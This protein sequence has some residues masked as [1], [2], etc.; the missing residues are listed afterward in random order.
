MVCKV[1]IPDRRP[2]NSGDG[3]DGL[4][5]C[6]SDVNETVVV[7]SVSGHPRV[8]NERDVLKRFQYRT[9]HIRPMVD[10]IEDPS[11]PTTIVLRHLDDHLLQASIQKPL[12][13]KEIKYVSRRIL[14][15]LSVLH[16][17]GYV[18]TGECLP[19]SSNHT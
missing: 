17:D 11:E 12:N 7:K 3:A 14:E 2:W 9:P 1:R 6:R 4:T 15:A 18:H 5:G 13:R 19:D 8:E 16:E 10:E